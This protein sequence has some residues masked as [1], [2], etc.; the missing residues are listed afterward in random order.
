MKEAEAMK[1]TELV[2]MLT[3]DEVARQL[4]RTRESVYR[5]AVKGSL[6][7]RRWGGRIVFLAAELN[8]FIQSPPARET[9]QAVG[10]RKASDG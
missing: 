8:E 5:A 4:G 2:R 10:G 7:A 1:Q 9:A 6:P 3:I